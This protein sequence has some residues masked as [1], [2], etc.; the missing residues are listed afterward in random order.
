VAPLRHLL[1]LLFI[2]I[3]SYVRVSPDSTFI[4]VPHYGVQFWGSVPV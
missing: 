3:N 4:R 2:A 1:S